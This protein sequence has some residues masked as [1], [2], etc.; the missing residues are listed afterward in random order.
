MGEYETAKDAFENGIAATSASGGSTTKLQTWLRKCQA[1][2]E[3]ESESSEDEVAA[4]PLPPAPVA[5]PAPRFRY[6]HR[7]LSGVG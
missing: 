3:D 1:E 6:G 4:P 2:L 7:P 5:P